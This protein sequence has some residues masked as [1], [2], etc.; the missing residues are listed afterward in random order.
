MF[1]CHVKPGQ[2]DTTATGRGNCVLPTI[3]QGQG[4]LTAREIPPFVTARIATSADGL[5]RPD[6]DGEWAVVIGVDDS[7]GRLADLDAFVR[8]SEPTA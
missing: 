3:T 6:L 1:G 7:L 5:F 8:G 4:A 2:R